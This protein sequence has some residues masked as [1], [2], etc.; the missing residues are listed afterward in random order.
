MTVCR[1]VRPVKSKLG[2]YDT[3]TQRPEKVHLDPPVGEMDHAW[4]VEDAPVTL[5]EFGDYECP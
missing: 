1:T 5:V 2:R 4:G 3:M